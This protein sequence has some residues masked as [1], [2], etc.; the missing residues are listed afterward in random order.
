MISVGKGRYDKTWVKAI[1]GWTIYKISRL[2]GAVPAYLYYCFPFSA[3]LKRFLPGWL[4][5]LLLRVCVYFLAFKSFLLKLYGFGGCFFTGCF[6]Y[7]LAA[8]AIIA[9]AVFLVF[10]LFCFHDAFCIHA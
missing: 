5:R 1:S 6:I 3:I 4:V 2:H 7:A 9:V 10:V 8:L